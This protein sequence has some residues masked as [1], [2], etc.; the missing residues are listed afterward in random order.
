MS[1]VLYLI[2]AI[3]FV[4]WA[5]CFFIYHAGSAIHFLLVIA[6]IA[7]LVSIVRGRRVA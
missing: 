2:A 7:V 5:T 3:L 6:V 1:R 4:V